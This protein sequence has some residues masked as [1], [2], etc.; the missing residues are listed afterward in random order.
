MYKK[1]KQKSK[2]KIQP[3]NGRNTHLHDLLFLLTTQEVQ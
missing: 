3:Q 2:K 1:D